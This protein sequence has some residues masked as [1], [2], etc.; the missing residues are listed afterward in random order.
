MSPEKKGDVI[1]LNYCHREKDNVTVDEEGMATLHLLL[2]IGRSE[3][4]KWLKKQ[5]KV[6]HVEDLNEW[7]QQLVFADRVIERLFFA[8]KKVI[9]EVDLEKWYEIEKDLNKRMMQ[10]GK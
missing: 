6:T 2:M 7:S 1:I 10:L 9:I 4:R 8:A 5:D 3:H